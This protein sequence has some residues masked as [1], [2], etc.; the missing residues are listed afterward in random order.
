MTTTTSV[1]AATA[2][3]LATKS[4]P[5][6]NVDRVLNPPKRKPGRPAKVTSS[7]AQPR[8]PGRPAKPKPQD[9][10]AP[11]P[12]KESAQPPEK[13]PVITKDSPCLKRAKVIVSQCS[14]PPVKQP[15][16]PLPQEDDDDLESD[17]TLDKRLKNRK[18]GLRKSIDSGK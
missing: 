8:G 12:K 4:K 9:A 14:R 13:S 16:P 7:S 5:V 15:P 10:L 2:A 18:S 1:S 6:V 3:A 17:E 11:A